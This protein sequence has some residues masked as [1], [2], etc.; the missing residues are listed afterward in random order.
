MTE[1]LRAV[2]PC[3]SHAAQGVAAAPLAAAS[4]ATLDEAMAALRARDAGVT[5]SLDAAK[6]AF[7][8]AWEPRRALSL[9]WSFDPE[10]LLR[11]RLGDFEPIGPCDQVC[12]VVKEE[13]E[14]QEFFS[15]IIDF[16]QLLTQ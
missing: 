2:T 12:A 13:V 7:R 3:A 14:E 5:D 1:R 9:P 15:Y 4:A 6:A 11:T 16:S 10:G 8:A